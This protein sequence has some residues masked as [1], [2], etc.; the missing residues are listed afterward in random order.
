MTDTASARNPA[1]PPS[2]AA[3]FSSY[4]PAQVV[5]GL[6]VVLAGVVVLGFSMLPQ[7]LPTIGPGFLT[8]WRLNSAAFPDDNGT[9]SIMFGALVLPA[10][11]FSLA[12]KSAGHRLRRRIA[13]A[14]VLLFT[15]ETVL[16]AAAVLWITGAGQDAATLI[17]ADPDES[18][19]IMVAPIGMLF[20]L[21]AAA[22]MYIL[23]RRT[24]FDA[25]SAEYFGP[26]KSTVVRVKPLSLVLHGLSVLVPLAVL[27]AVI[28]LPAMAVERIEAGDLNDN[29]P[30]GDPVAWP[31]SPG[32]DFETARAA[33]AVVLG[34]IVGAIA[35]SLLKKLLYRTI[36]RGTI[37]RPVDDSTKKRWG[38]VTGGAEHYPIAIAGGLLTGSLLFFAPVD[39]V[40]YTPDTASA[41]VLA[42]IAAAALVLGVYLIASIWK[43]GRDPLYD[44]PLRQ[45]D[46]RQAARILKSRR[47]R[48]HSR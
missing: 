29:V 7:L 44:S 24:D 26:A 38:A 14:C 30:D 21:A 1:D 18:T 37:K 25:R 39:A 23:A 40:Y 16:L 42:S 31:Y 6:V 8:M 11:G 32:M 47:R 2:E 41:T 15:A 48:G 46:P 36:L 12:Y 13:G 35:S 4:G 17:G 33:Y 45:A 3:E 5:L 9:V 43:N 34:I 10:A 19:T 20:C 27:A 22:I 28:S